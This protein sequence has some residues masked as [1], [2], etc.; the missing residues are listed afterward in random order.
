MNEKRPNF[1]D[2][3]LTAVTH[4]IKGR[5]CHCCKGFIPK[6]IPALRIDRW[7]CITYLCKDCVDHFNKQLQKIPAIQ[8][9]LL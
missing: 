9:Q 8:G 6:N 5:E 2:M 1:P 4:S 7:G 3:A